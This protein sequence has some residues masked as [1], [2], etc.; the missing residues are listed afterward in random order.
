[1]INFQLKSVHKRV[2]TF[3][4]QIN[5]Y[6]LRYLAFKPTKWPKRRSM[7]LQ[8]SSK[9]K[10]KK[11]LRISSRGLTSKLYINGS[12]NILSSPFGQFRVTRA[13][14]EYI[15]TTSWR[16][17]VVGAINEFLSKNKVKA[18]KKTSPDMRKPWKKKGREGNEIWAIVT[19]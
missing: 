1:M 2:S 18:S 9:N 10:I 5:I 15:V 14:L 4:I 13:P 6:S 16:T 19:R 17:R 8:N 11:P 3:L 12:T 7:S